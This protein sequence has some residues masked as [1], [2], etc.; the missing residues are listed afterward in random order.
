MLL[1]SMGDLQSADPKG[2]SQVTLLMTVWPRQ[3]PRWSP[4]HPEKCRHPWLC[5]PPPPPPELAQLNFWL[6]EWPLDLLGPKSV[7]E[8]GGDGVPE[9]CLY[10]KERN[11]NSEP[12]CHR[13][14]SLCLGDLSCQLHPYF[15]RPWNEGTVNQFWAEVPR[16]LYC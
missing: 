15:H 8:R 10:H 13:W 7:R 5:K 11:M 1:F 16:R 14:L 9:R 6:S 12:G 3:V 4:A 2:E